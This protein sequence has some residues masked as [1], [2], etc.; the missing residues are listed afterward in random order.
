MNRAQLSIIVLSLAT[1]I[2]MALL[3]PWVHLADDGT[4]QSM[5]YGP[6]WHPPVV[7][8]QQGINFFGLKLEVEEQIRATKVDWERL[9]LQVVVVTLASGTA[10]FIAGRT[11]PK[12]ISRTDKPSKTPV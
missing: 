6:L 8:Q 4:R 11:F 2:V 9:L 10:Y 5:G 3:P 7:E 1:L 12:S